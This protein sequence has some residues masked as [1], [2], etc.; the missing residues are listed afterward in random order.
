MI[1]FSV[2]LA[3][4]LMFF[5]ADSQNPH[6]LFTAI[7]QQ[8]VDDCSVDYKNLCNDDRLQTY[9]TQLENTDPDTIASEDTRLAFWINA[10]N[11]FT[12]KVICE[13]YPVDSINDLHWGGL[14]VGTIFNKTVWDKKFIHIGGGALSLNNIEH[15]IIRQEFDDPRIHF[16]LV[17][18]AKSC[19]PLREEAYTGSQL[20]EQ[21]QE[22]GRIFFSQESKNRF[23]VENKVA[24][25]SKIMDW[26]DDD[27]ADN[28][29]DL[30]LYVTQ[31]LPEHVAEAIKADPAAW[32]IKHTHYDWSLNNGQE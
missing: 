30:L 19:P 25:L 15:A 24:Y 3:A 12:L 20:D 23:D 29:K 27:F 17:C 26:Y 5:P 21:L 2:L 8:Y 16:A 13:G 32:Q 28:D 6:A 14:I 22:Q 7:L 9:L 18:A 31:F 4:T 11:A 10:Y 1:A